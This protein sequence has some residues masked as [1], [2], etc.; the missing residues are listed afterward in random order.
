[1]PDKQSRKPET[2][3]SGIGR[4][5]VEAALDRALEQYYENPCR[6][7]FFE[8]CGVMINAL[9][10]SLNAVCPNE[11]RDTG[12]HYKQFP[13]PDYGYAWIVYTG[14]EKNPEMKEPETYAFVTWRDIFFKAAEDRNCSGIVINPYSG[15]QAYVWLSSVHVRRIIEYAAEKAKE[16]P[17][18]SDVQ[19]EEN[20]IPQKDRDT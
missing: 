12:V 2:N 3:N 5:I 8:I 18:K 9:V 20:D 16:A 14:T 10:F 4:M 7:T 15:H 19:S 1:M 11:L 13:V 17:W 6:E